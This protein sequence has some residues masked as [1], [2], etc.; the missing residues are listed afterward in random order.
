[1]KVKFEEKSFLENDLIF[2]QAKEKT[3]EIESIIKDIKSTKTVLQCS[4]NEKNLMIP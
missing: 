3:K 1:M 2:M 4:F